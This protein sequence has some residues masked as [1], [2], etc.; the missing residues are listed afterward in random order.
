MEKAALRGSFFFGNFMPAALTTKT[1]FRSGRRGNAVYTG[2]VRHPI[3]ME[4]W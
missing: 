1:L 4:R 2:S 3:G